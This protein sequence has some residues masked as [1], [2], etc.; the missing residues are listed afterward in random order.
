MRLEEDARIPQDVF[1]LVKETTGVGD[2]VGATGR[3]SPL[4]LHE[5]EKMLLDSRKPDET[6]TVKLM[7]DKGEQINIT[8]GPFEGYDGTVDELLPDQGKVRVLVTIFGRLAPLE[9]EEW[10]ISKLDEA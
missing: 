5:I 1:F 2:F 6:P 7:F 4:A 8:E 3:P 10:M 9:V